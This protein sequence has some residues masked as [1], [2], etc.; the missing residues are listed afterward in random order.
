MPT[1]A[2]LRSKLAQCQTVRNY[3]GTRPLRGVMTGQRPA[4]TQDGPTDRNDP[5]IISKS[6][7]EELIAA[8]PRSAEIIRPYLRGRDVKPWRLEPSGDHIIVSSRRIKIDDYPAVLR[9]LEALRD[10]LQPTTSGQQWYELRD[11]PAHLDLYGVPKVIW[12]ELCDGPRFA[13]DTAGHV[14]SSLTYSLPTSD[15]FL[16]AVLSSSV[17]WWTVRQ[18]S[19]TFRAGAGDIPKFDSAKQW[20]RVTP[21]VVNNLPVPTTTEGERAEVADLARHGEATAPA[22][23]GGTRVDRGPMTAEEIEFRYPHT[24]KEDRRFTTAGGVRVYAG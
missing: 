7:P 14:P 8:D 21:A 1:A 3:A 20:W 18:V 11:N 6:K 17:S 22:D 16:L 19:P 4:M 10:R 12:S 13:L 9:H 23:V 24:D 5:F 15:L 2:L